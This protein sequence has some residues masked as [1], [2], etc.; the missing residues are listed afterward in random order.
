MNKNKQ[1][2]I[3]ENEF[4]KINNKELQDNYDKVQCVCTAVT[5]VPNEEAWPN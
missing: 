4:E 5:I 3:E 2:G 1:N